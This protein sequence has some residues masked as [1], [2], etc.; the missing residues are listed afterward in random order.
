MQDYQACLAPSPIFVRLNAPRRIL[1]SFMRN[2]LQ[3]LQN[4]S[5]YPRLL[6][7]AI[8]TLRPYA[9]TFLHLFRAAGGI[10][11]GRV[12]IGD[13]IFWCTGSALA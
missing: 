2:E 12:W 8:L 5:Y 1:A 7:S 9:P 11:E 10:R 13:V 6:P 4:A 3:K